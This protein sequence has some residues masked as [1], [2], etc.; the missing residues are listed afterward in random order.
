MWVVGIDTVPEPLSDDPLLAVFDGTAAVFGVP[1]F[2]VRLRI[3]PAEVEVYGLAT[4]RSDMD[5]RVREG[6]AATVSN[7]AVHEDRG[8]TPAVD[9]GRPVA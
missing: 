7:C 2:H 3:R 6:C 8:H 1:V 4:G 9:K 5:A